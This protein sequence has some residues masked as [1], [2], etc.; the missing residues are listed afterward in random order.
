MR[1]PYPRTPLLGRNLPS[2]F[3]EGEKVFDKRV[4]ER[5]PIGTSETSVVDELEGQ[6]FSVDPAPFADEWRRATIRR[7]ILI[8]TLWSVHWR[9]G[10]NRIENI[11]GVYGVIA[12]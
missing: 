9:A 2:T 12:P 4:K 1:W 3:S 11:A 8:Q 7:G 5:F 10:A 6:G